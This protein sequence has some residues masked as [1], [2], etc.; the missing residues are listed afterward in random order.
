[1]ALKEFKRK[2]VTLCTIIY[3]DCDIIY[4]IM[5]GSFICK[6]VRILV[7][8]SGSVSLLMLATDFDLEMVE[9]DFLRKSVL[10]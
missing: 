9:N 6:T 5:C 7:L 8:P 2:N 1:M 10:S 4:A 3:L